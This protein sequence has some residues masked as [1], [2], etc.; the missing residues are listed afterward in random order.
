MHKLYRS[1]LVALCTCVHSDM[2]CMSTLFAPFWRI[3]HVRCSPE[4]SHVRK[5]LLCVRSPCFCRNPA[6]A[7]LLPACFCFLTKHP[8]CNSKLVPCCGDWTYKA[9]QLL[10]FNL[11]SK[12]FPASFPIWFLELSIRVSVQK[13]FLLLFSFFFLP[14]NGPASS[15][16]LPTATARRLKRLFIAAC[17]RQQSCLLS[18]L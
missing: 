14:P 15:P 3:K 4:R 17:S 18:S 1:N 7:F 2:P 5:Q 10:I 11:G 13:S 12:N 9:C 6:A 16:R 8:I